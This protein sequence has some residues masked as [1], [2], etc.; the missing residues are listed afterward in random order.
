MSD[1][2]RV[3]IDLWCPLFPLPSSQQKWC[4]HGLFT[5]FYSLGAAVKYLWLSGARFIP[6]CFWEVR[7]HSVKRDASEQVQCRHRFIRDAKLVITS[8]KLCTIACWSSLTVFFFF[9]IEVIS[10]SI[11]VTSIKPW[12][13]YNIFLLT[14]PC[15][16]WITPAWVKHAHR[17]PNIQ[18]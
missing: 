11:R 4:Y 8:P 13:E 1:P 12:A 5:L 15:F 17:N 9:H 10:E 7:A 6:D 16:P 14:V 2:L 18:C 3:V